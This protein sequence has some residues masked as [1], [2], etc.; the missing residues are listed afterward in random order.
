M[1]APEPLFNAGTSLQLSSVVSLAARSR[2]SATFNFIY[3]SK[4]IRCEVYKE[5]TR[6]AT[7]DTPRRYFLSSVFDLVLR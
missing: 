5:V 6:K 1:A 7:H 2:N 4:C 3:F